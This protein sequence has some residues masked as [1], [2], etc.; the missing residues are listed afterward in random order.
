MSR[1]AII[2]I[3]LLIA[4]VA[5]GVAGALVAMGRSG[6]EEKQEEPTP[7]GAREPAGATE[8]E[9]PGRGR[10]FETIRKGGIAAPGLAFTIVSP[11]EDDQLAPEGPPSLELRSGAGDY[12]VIRPWIEALAPLPVAGEADDQ[13]IQ[14]VAADLDT[15]WRTLLSIAR[16][17]LG[18][19]PLRVLV[20]HY[21]RAELAGSCFCVSITYHTCADP[22]LVEPPESR[23]VTRP[24]RVRG[25]LFDVHRTYQIDAGTARLIAAGVEAQI[26]LEIL[27]G[28]GSARERRSPAD[29]LG[30]GS[31]KEIGVDPIA[32]TPFRHLAGGVRRGFVWFD[33]SLGL[34]T[35]SPW[36]AAYRISG[37]TQGMDVAM[38]ENL[39]PAVLTALLALVERA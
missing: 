23:E 25:I 7:G 14:E 24:R 34:G 31:V 10:F 19:P 27:P 30:E 11:R 5:G 16:G 8:A 6:G 39:P 28:E 17:P 12:S 21:P 9:I 26:Q 2:T 32:M 35:A 13:L 37:T 3:A 22:L 18:L 4:A 20:R 1:T 38:K 29:H 36:S 15:E 33:R